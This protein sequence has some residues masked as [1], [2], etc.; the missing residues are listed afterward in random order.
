MDTEQLEAAPGARKHAQASRLAILVVAAAD[1][2]A[3]RLVRQLERTNDGAASV[4]LLNV[5]DIQHVD[6]SGTASVDYLSTCAHIWRHLGERDREVDGASAFEPVRVVI[7]SRQ[8]CLLQRLVPRLQTARNIELAGAPVTHAALLFPSLARYASRLLLLDK[9]LLD[10][11]GTQSLSEMRASFPQ[12][13]VVLLWDEICEPLVREA[14]QDRLHGFLFTHATP[15]LCLRAIRA[16]SRGEL[17]LSRALLAKAI[18]SMRA[19]HAEVDEALTPRQRQIVDFVRRGLTN[20]EIA[21][22]LG[23][24]EDTVKKHLQVVFG[25]LGVHRRALVIARID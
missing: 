21:N 17:W 16:V 8:E 24:T 9:A 3:A 20:K 23:I 5:R 10:E 22:H 13:R 1:L 14:L 2:D 25:K 15:E 11:L 4:S 6:A 7:A 19:P 12:L 18:A